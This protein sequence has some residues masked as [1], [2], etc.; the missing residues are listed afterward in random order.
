MKQVVPDTNIFLRF[1]LNDNPRQVREFEK[2]LR[3]VKKSDIFE[4]LSI[5]D[6]VSFFERFGFRNTLS[7]QWPLFLR[8]RDRYNG[9]KR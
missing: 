8:L 2:L 4:I 7:N 9:V 3:Q 6:K 5:T 1:I